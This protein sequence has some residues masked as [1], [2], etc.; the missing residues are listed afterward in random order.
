MGTF[1][2]LLVANSVK[3]LNQDVGMR[4]FTAG[5]HPPSPQPAAPDCCAGAVPEVPKS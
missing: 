2:A 4:V 1:K 3:H 5:V